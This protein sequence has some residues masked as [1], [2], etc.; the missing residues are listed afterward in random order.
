[1]S[2]KE[3]LNTLKAKL[4]TVKVQI[5]RA[6]NK[7]ESAIEKFPKYDEA[8]TPDRVMNRLAVEIQ[9]HHERLTKEFK[10]DAIAIAKDMETS[11]EDQITKIGTDMEENKERYNKDEILIEVFAR[12]AAKDSKEIT[13]VIQNTGTVSYTHLTLPTNR[14]V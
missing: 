13:Q 14:E 2:D 9:D 8:T 5:T 11:V 12:D 4:I 3:S 7:I 10:T 1:M 6:L